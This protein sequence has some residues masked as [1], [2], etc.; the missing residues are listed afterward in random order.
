[1]S[2]VIQAVHACAHPGQAKT[3]ELFLQLFHPDMPYARLRETVNKALSGCVVCAQAKA[4]GGP[5]SD[6]CEPF[7]V[8]SFHFSPV[9]IDFVDLPEVRNQSSKT[10]I[11][12]NHAMVIVCRLTGYV[13]AIPCCKERLTSR[14]AAELFLHR[15]GFLMGLPREIKANN[16][17]IISST[18]PNALCNLAGIEQAKSIIY[19]PESN[20][21]A[22]RAVQSTINTLR[23]YLLSRK[24]SWLDILLVAL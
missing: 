10:K 2:Q 20:G 3:L 12:A 8:P 6:S 7:L 1:M 9:A 19:R 22:E 14:K 5:H 24:G 21:R 13:M 15:C 4:R 18:F 23:Q 16:Q 17:S 11:W